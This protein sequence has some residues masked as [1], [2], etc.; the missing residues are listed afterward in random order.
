MPMANVPRID[1]ALPL[2]RAPPRGGIATG[3]FS[4]RWPFIVII[5]TGIGKVEIGV[6][7]VGEIAGLHSGLIEG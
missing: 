3:L 7:V 5:L 1:R 4:R 2:V 6:I